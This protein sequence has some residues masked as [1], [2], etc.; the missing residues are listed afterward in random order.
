MLEYDESGLERELVRRER[1]DCSDWVD[2]TPGHHGVITVVQYSTTV[3][4]RYY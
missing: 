2:I 1:R 3:A 4:Q